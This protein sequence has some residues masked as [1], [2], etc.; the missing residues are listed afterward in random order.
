MQS[1]AWRC[2]KRKAQSMQTGVQA[3]GVQTWRAAPTLTLY[4]RSDGSAA[5]R[6]LQTPHRSAATLRVTEIGFRM[7]MIVP[8]DPKK[9]SR[10]L[11]L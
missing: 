4:A 1:Y 9:A 5:G 2:S 3:G 7:E 10:G 8:E 11:Y 6:R